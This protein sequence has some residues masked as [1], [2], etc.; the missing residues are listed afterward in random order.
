MAS[1]PTW[2]VSTKPYLVA[3]TTTDDDDDDDDDDDEVVCGAPECRGGAHGGE[4]R[5]ERRQ[6][7]GAAAVGGGQRRPANG[8]RAEGSSQLLGKWR[9]CEAPCTILP[10]TAG[11][12]WFVRDPRGW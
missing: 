1:T 3:M 4:Q 10:C 12:S 8:Q 5:G 11:A 2:N 7:V 9:R 6:R